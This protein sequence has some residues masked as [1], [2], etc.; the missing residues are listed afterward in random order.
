MGDTASPQGLDLAYGPPTVLQRSLRPRAG[1]PPTLRP[2]GQ[3]YPGNRALALSCMKHDVPRLVRQVTHAT[4]ADHLSAFSVS[5]PKKHVR[6]N[7]DSSDDMVYKR[8]RE[9]WLLSGAMNGRSAISLVGWSTLEAAYFWGQCRPCCVMVLLS[10]DEVGC[11]M[12]ER[13]PS[14][15]AGVPNRSL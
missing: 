2:L 4:L 13:M 15:G 12:N 10:G 5:C 6:G 11:P 1:P 7:L 9:R 8:A 3:A 14:S